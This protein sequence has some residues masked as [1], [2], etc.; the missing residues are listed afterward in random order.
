MMKIVAIIIVIML[1]MSCA[2]INDKQSYEP[3]RFE[4]ISEYLF[5]ING[6]VFT[7]AT[8]Q[9][10]FTLYNPNLYAIIITIDEIEYT[11]N[12]HENLTIHTP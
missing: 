4:I 10:P 5:S 8:A 6:K 11:I 2:L 9:T 12:S 3:P 7:K 1:L